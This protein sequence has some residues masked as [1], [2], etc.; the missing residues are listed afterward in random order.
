M[1][2]DNEM[3]LL[4]DT[5]PLANYENQI[6]INYR[7]TFK[8]AKRV[9][10]FVKKWLEKAK[11]IYSPDGDKLLYADVMKDFAKL[12]DYMS[13]FETDWRNQFKMQ[14]MRIKYCEELLGNL[15]PLIHMPICRECWNEAALGYSAQ[16]LLKWRFIIEEINTSPKIHNEVQQLTE[17]AI[18]KFKN[19][20]SSF[21]GKFSPLIPKLTYDEKKMCMDAHYKLAILYG[22]AID[23]GNPQSI[24]MCIYYFKTFVEECSKDE[25]LKIELK[26]DIK[27][28][29]EQIEKINA[30]FGQMRKRSN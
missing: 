10:L 7:T 18:G 13:F 22:R 17:S 27:I 16:L 9:F 28:S 23:T 25:R 2:L 11:D 21:G 26:S 6:T 19:L 15:D 1:E 8:E 14:K 24:K 30:A 5:L 12:Y 29:R 20:I 3:P 4:F